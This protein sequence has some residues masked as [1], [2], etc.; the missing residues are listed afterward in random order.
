MM[1]FKRS[2]FLRSTDFYSIGSVR[3]NFDMDCMREVKIPIPSIKIQ[4]S[5]VNIFIC[6]LKRKEINEKLKLQIKDL[7]PLLI[8][9]SV[10]ESREA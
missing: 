7:C 6:Y 9:G 2:E 5:I 10:E 3:N 1:W 4:E 8:K